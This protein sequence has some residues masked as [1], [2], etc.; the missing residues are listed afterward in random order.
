MRIDKFDFSVR[1]SPSMF[2]PKRAAN[3]TDRDK[4]KMLSTKCSRQWLGIPFHKTYN[5]KL[6][7]KSNVG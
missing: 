2:R 4:T 5:S 7:K 6:E 1:A 3:A